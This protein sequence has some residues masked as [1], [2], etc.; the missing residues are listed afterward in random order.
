MQA[1]ADT[2][3]LKAL[4]DRNDPYHRWAATVFPQYAPWATCE[5][6]LTETA[7]LSRAPQKVMQLVSYGDVRVSFAAE[8]EAKRLL[9]LLGKYQD[10]KMDLADACLVCMSE[11]DDS[12]VIFTLD[13]ED[14]TVYR[15]HGNQVIPCNFPEATH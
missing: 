9:E 12:A 7:H 6:V 15:K 5:A 10:Y 14:F 2:G 3:L 13:R 1:V 8:A 11:L 4:L